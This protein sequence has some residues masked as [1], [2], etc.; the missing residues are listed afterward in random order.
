[1]KVSPST[2]SFTGRYRV[3][4]AA[5]EELRSLSSSSISSGLPELLHRRS[6]TKRC[7]PA[8]FSS[9]TGL[10]SQRSA[11]GS[12]GYVGCFR[13]AREAAHQFPAG[14]VD[15]ELHLLGRRLQVVVDHR[16]VGRILGRRLFRRQ[17]RAQEDIVVDA[18]RCRRLKEP[19]TAPCGWLAICRSGVMSSRIQNARPCVAMTRSS[20]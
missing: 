20:P 5:R 7:M 18:N 19:R 3:Q 8:V 1:M 6:Q 9:T 2:V 11:I 17:R 4:H 10:G 13:A 14:I 15:F 12:G 16:A